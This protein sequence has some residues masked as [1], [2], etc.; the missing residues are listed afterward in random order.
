MQFIF[1]CPITTPLVQRLSLTDFKALV[2]AGKPQWWEVL[3]GSYMPDP[4]GIALQARLA[5]LVGPNDAES[6]QVLQDL[7]AKGHALALAWAMNPVESRDLSRWMMECHREEINVLAARAVRGDGVAQRA[8][9]M[10]SA[11]LRASPLGPAA[12]NAIGSLVA[13]QHYMRL[14]IGVMPE[15]NNAFWVLRTRS[16]A[17][18]LENVAVTR[19]AL[20]QVSYARCKLMG[21]PWCGSMQWQPQK[22]AACFPLEQ[23]GLWSKPELEVHRAACGR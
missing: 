22:R 2:A 16:F 9:D 7:E 18:G 11:R 10:M 12:I 6:L 14:R 17:A 23:G 15:A 8:M 13:A 3:N 19:M 21:L 5:M 4:N 20:Q 1:K